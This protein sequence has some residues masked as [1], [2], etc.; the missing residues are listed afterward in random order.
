MIK[1]RVKTEFY[2]IIDLCLL[3]AS[4]KDKITVLHLLPKLKVLT[5]FL[6]SQTQ[7]HIHTGIKSLG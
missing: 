2:Y 1:Y 3:C 5:T 6:L 7:N 4:S